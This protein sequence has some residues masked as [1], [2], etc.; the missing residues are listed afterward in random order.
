MEAEALSD[1]DRADMEKLAEDLVNAAED[2]AQSGLVGHA[3][4]MLK[5]RRAVRVM[6]MR[7]TV[8]EPPP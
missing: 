2:I 6:A 7:L 8:K 3:G 4:L 5:A 1:K